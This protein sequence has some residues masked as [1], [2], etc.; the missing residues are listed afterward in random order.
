MLDA[1]AVLLA[2]R[3]GADLRLIGGPRLDMMLAPIPAGRSSGTEEKLD[4]RVAALIRQ[5]GSGICPGEQ[6]VQV[7]LLI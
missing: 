5:A 4:C 6:T 1:H 7:L 2:T 3:F